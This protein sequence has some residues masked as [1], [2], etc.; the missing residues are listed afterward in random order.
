MT[1]L[2]GGFAPDY[3]RPVVPSFAR[4]HVSVALDPPEVER[5]EAFCAGRGL[6]PVVVVLTALQAA[7]WRCTGQDEIVAGILASS[8]PVGISTCVPEDPT[9]DEFLSA[10]AQAAQAPPG[11]TPSGDAWAPLFHALLVVEN[12]GPVLSSGPLTADDV[13]AAA[14]SLVR[15]DLVFLVSSDGG[16]L[17]LECDAAADLFELRSAERVLGCV[18]T[19]LA[20][21]TGNPGGRLADVS[22]LPDDERAL[23]SAASAGPRV[24]IRSERCVHE[25][26]ES[27]SRQTPERIA[28]ICGGE[29]LTYGA[30]NA[31]A[32]RLAHLLREQGAGPPTLVAV[33]LE[34]SLDLPVAL[35]GVVKAGAAYVAIDPALPPQRQRF[36]VEDAAVAVVVGHS[37]QA[38]TFS[39]AVFIDLANERDRLTAM[40]SDN[41][42][43]P[44]TSADLMYVSYT[45][46]SMGRPKGVEVEHRCVV[47]LLEAM[48]LAPGIEPDDTLLAVTTPSFDIA[49]LELFLPLTVGARV[50]IAA[51]D[52]VADGARL[53]GLIVEHGVT[54]LQAT[55]AT[56]Q[57]LLDSGWSGSQALTALCGGEALPPGL[58]RQLLPRVRSLWNLYG[59]TETTIWSTVHRVHS[60]PSAVP[61]GRP[62]ANT[63]AYVLDSHLRPVPTGV[64]GELYL[65][66]AGVARGY[67]Q[68]P[69]LTSERFL[70]DPYGEDRGG[71]MYRTGDLARF[72]SRGDLEFLG[73]LDHQVKIRGHRIEL[74]EVEAMLE[75]HEAISRAVVV[76]RKHET[77]PASLVGYVVCRDRQTVTEAQVR[78]FLRT[79]APEP[80]IPARFVFLDALPLTTVGK[81]DRAA[82][83]TP[84]ELADSAVGR[85]YTERD[86]TA[87][88]CEVLG[89][90]DVGV[91]ENFFD[92]GGDSFLLARLGSQLRA[93]FQRDLSTVDM[94]RRP[95]VRTQAAW[96]DGRE[97]ASIRASRPETVEDDGD[98][99]AIVGLACRFPGA[100]DAREFWRNLRDGVES[101]TFFT[102]AELREAG[103]PPE[104]L[105]DPAYVRAAPTI[106]GLELFDAAFFGMSPAEAVITDPQHRLFLECAGSALDDAAF[107]PARFP[108]VVG[109]FG[110]SSMNTYLV[111]NVV[112]HVHAHP[113]V[114]RLAVMIGNDK[115]FLT[116]RVSY[117]LGLTGPSVAVQT[118]CST[119]LVA[120]HL[121]RASLLA[122]E[123]DMALAGGVSARPRHGYTYV[124]GGIESPDGHCRPFDVRAAGTVF[125]S[126]VGI[127]VLRRLRDALRDGD[128]IRAVI[129]GSAVNND[130]RSKLGFTAPSADSQAECIRA[131]HA[132]AGVTPRT[133]TYVEAHGTGTILGDPIEVEGLARAFGTESHHS[134]AI[135]SVKASIGHLDA[136]AGIAGLIKTAL[137][138]EHAYIPP[139]LHFESPNPGIDLANTPFHIASTLRPWP[140]H[141]G[142]RRAGVSALGI[143]GTN[144]HVVLEEAPEIASSPSPR[145]YEL[146]VLSARTDS[147]LATL[148]RDLAQR[149]EDEPSLLLADVAYTLHTGRKMFDFR[150][151]VV[152]RDRQE[153]IGAL[154]STPVHARARGEAPI[155]VFLFPGQGSGPR[156]GLSSE[157][158]DSEPGFRS[159]VDTCASILLPHLG[160]DIRDVLHRGASCT[161]STRLVQPATFVLDYALARLWMEWGVV[162]AAMIGHS[163]GELVAACLAG[164]MSLEDAL[165]LVA[166]RG[167]LMEAL[168]AGAMLA[169][170]M[171]EQDLLALLDGDT[172]VSVAAVNSPTQCVLSGPGPAVDVIQRRLT[173]DGVASR[174]LDVE[175]A[176]HSAMM[177][178]MLDPF[179][180]VLATIPMQAPSIPYLS[181]VTGTWITPADVVDRDYWLRH[182]RQTVRF[183]DC[184]REVLHE[185]NRLLL[186]VGAG[187]A[188]S[189]FAQTSLPRRRHLV[190]STLHSGRSVMA[191]LLAATGRMWAE[192]VKIDGAA[193]FRYEHRRRVPLPTYPFEGQRFWLEPGWL[194]SDVTAPDPADNGTSTPK[195]GLEEDLARLWRAALGS[196][197][198]ADDDFFELGGDSLV[199]VGL[200]RRI[201]EQLGVPATVALIYA[202]PTVRE[203]AGSLR[204]GGD[205][206]M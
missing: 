6:P 176:F 193:M 64:A 184:L 169:V 183:A 23:L 161:Q 104:R 144:A 203:L 73:R 97:E 114:D 24:Q 179:A 2:V 62:I 15:C 22:L 28:V 93:R 57:I 139:S 186:E 33:V 80:M 130:G 190:V 107:D 59:P 29:S 137:A 66:G 122:G 67:R 77:G 25:L 34:R 124:A 118:A 32:N 170:R 49:V 96:I 128:H 48:R 188:L 63:R 158:H 177:D 44:T 110:G 164:V 123:C 61:I 65:A 42:T 37:D 5:F 72:T 45:S 82:L 131:A 9:L 47:N 146:L 174:M 1:S 4:G 163:L 83:P 206:I 187:H 19:M 13:V 39:G 69:G 99:I 10:V 151:A 102:D 189:D 81:V 20:E 94:I 127:V 40:P 135:G 35:L 185:P 168:P 115:D 43:W 30:L 55:P 159:H 106:D 51:G 120:V 91:E 196:D 41:P 46:G 204:A 70:P 113:M 156:Q 103:V 68:R 175:R 50:V 36:I 116:T 148:A 119:S 31:R 166:A 78:A 101:I 18:R 149:L 95:T 26:V 133:I 16:A 58:A 7:L 182:I 76:A 143:G 167:R 86:L 71:R 162:P 88:W 89:V 38:S 201:R 145:P 108:G 136:A 173:T 129:R 140:R 12:L 90:D 84:P 27:Q 180:E 197:V 171:S 56:W 157:I 194:S 165:A 60:A 112:P 11:D 54:L 152:C 134:C 109:V 202:R 92:V 75:R 79:I 160:L 154:G 111:D 200:A 126:G 14:E 53:Q 87:I 138:L 100:S 125:G 117:K 17:R 74:G 8:G 192:G 21:V 141:A 205:E 105:D 181:G 147:A 155:P 121:A 178:P 195:T 132:A 150:R 198:H 191:D 98:A 85:G 199:A 153:A 172:A 142:P 3:P 52:D